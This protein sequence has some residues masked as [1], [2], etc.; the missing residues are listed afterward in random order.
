MFP[1]LLS[2][3]VHVHS[4]PPTVAVRPLGRRTPCASS[5]GLRFRFLG[6]SLLVPLLCLLGCSISL[7]DSPEP[8]DDLPTINLRA[9]GVPSGFGSGP[10]EEGKRAVMD[11]FRK[12]FPHVNPVSTTGLQ[13]PGG[14]HHDMLPFM[15]IAGDIAPDVMSVNFR[16]SQTYISMGLLYPLDDYVEELA[17]VTIEDGHLLN[18]D[19]YIAELKKGANWARIE[20]RVPRQCWEVMRRMG[21]EGDGYHTYAFP[22]GPVA[23]GLKYDRALFSEH[24]DEGVELRPPRDWEEMLAW[25]KIFTDPERSH[26]GIEIAAM[27]PAFVFV[28]FLYGAGGDVVKRVAPDEVEYFRDKKNLANVQVGD[29][30]CVFDTPEAIEAAHFWARLSHEKVIRDGKLV[31]RGVY[32][33]SNEGGGDTVHFGMSFRYLEDRFLGKAVDQ[34]FGF[35]PLPAGPT[36]L[37]RSQ[38]NA[39]MVGIF[40]GLKNDDRRREAAW[41]YIRFFDGPEARK[42]R[43]EKLVE[44]GLGTLIPSKLLMSHNQDGR[45]DSVIRRISPDLERTHQIAASGG[46]PEPYGKNCQYV[47]DEMRFPLMAIA[48]NQ[49]I[50]AAIDAGDKT[51]AKAIIKG[52]ME[53]GTKRIN[54]KMLGNLSPQQARHRNIIAWIVIAIVL[55]SFAIVMRMVFKAFTPEHHRELAG[56]QFGKYWK[57]Y[58]LAAPALLLIG[59]W[60]YWPMLKGTV[61]A[62]QDYSVMGDSQWSGTE[63]FSAVL[64]DREFWMS[65]WVSILYALLFMFFGFCTPIILAFLLSEVPRGKTFFRTIYYLPAVLSGLVVII[66]WKN[67]YTP[68]GMVNQVL[69]GV[70]WALNLLPGIHFGFFREDWL[71]NPTWALFFCLI[72]TIWAGMGPG[73]LIYMAALKTIPEELYEAADIDG[74]GIRQKIFSIS[75]PMIK[76]LVMINFTGAMIGAIRG[77]GGYILAMTGG[78]PYTET[79]GATEVIGLRLFYTTF[80]HLKFGEG[81]AMAWI[82]GALLIGFTVFQLKRLSNVEFR[83]AGTD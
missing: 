57:A 52:I 25:A 11:M 8:A 66:M 13:L 69:N 30:V 64:F 20:D 12:R 80:G 79:G 50:R 5:V 48:S 44:A 3:R 33:T 68:D 24:A 17:G 54:E 63:N 49:E 82:I 18:N 61:I 36:G 4:H 29:W 45:Y 77:S 76:I 58:L 21:R 40:A 65:L 74:A 62:F 59:I 9:H 67:F 26:Y 73:C 42:V 32:Q 10:I 15:Q 35:G 70:V 28:N 43:V 19:D 23:L 27:E 47:Y 2:A 6:F 22:I 31:C 60:M 16:Q 75:I 81:A 41:Q 14:R 39:R 37:Q 56:W 53:R 72:P 46:V 78:G 7:A 38:F 51:R 1:A 71:S 34:T 55:V 83:V